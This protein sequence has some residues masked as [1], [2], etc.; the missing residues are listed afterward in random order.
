MNFRDLP[1]CCAFFSNNEQQTMADSKSAIVCFVLKSMLL[2][3]A[4]C[5]NAENQTLKRNKI[6]SP[7][8]IIYSLPSS[9]TKPESLQA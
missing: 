4:L 2:G 3:F 9:R 5:N 7:S 1:C 8:A 6:T